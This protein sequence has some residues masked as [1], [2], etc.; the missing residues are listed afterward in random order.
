M[1]KKLTILGVLVLA[2]AACGTTQQGGSGN[3]GNNGDNPGSGG[4]ITN[5]ATAVEALEVSEEPAQSGGEEVESEVSQSDEVGLPFVFVPTI[6]DFLDIFESPVAEWDCSQSTVSGD[7]TDADD[8]GIAV[9]ARYEIKC[10]KSFADVPVFDDVV[11][12]ER[13]GTLVMQDADDNDPYSG[14]HAQG[15]ITYNYVNENFTAHHSFDRTWSRAGNGYNYN[16][17]NAWQWQAAGISYKIAH[18]H[19]GSYTPDDSQDPFAAGWVNEQAE[20]KQFVNGALE[21][22]VKEDVNLHLNQTCDPAADDGTITFTWSLGEGN[23][24]MSYSLVVK[25]TGCGEFEV[26][27]SLPID[28]DPPE[29]F[30]PP[31]NPPT[32]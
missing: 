2:L 5:Q 23:D 3:G 21:Y 24:L 17:N 30:D 27:Q 22:T 28:Q 19:G 32:P 9:N 13:Q 31:F 26:E 14:Y 4:Q 20:V 15:D 18:T 6:N 8:D 1:I 7:A 29:G 16:L 12:V 25:F 10:T 11:V